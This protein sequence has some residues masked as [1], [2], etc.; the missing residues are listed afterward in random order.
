M[1]TATTR[2]AILLSGV[3][4][5]FDTPQGQYTAVAEITLEIPA[6]QF[7]AI[8][9]PSGCGKSTILGMIAGLAQPSVGAVRIGGEPLRGINHRASYM[10]Q[11]DALLPWK[12][13]LDNVAFGPELQGVP[14]RQARARAM[15][16]LERVGLHGFE[17]R[18]PH[19][20]S[21]GMRKRICL[22]Q[23]LVNDPEIMLMDE[24]F[25]GLDVQTRAMVE[26]EVLDLWAGSNKTVV[27]VTHDLE[28]AIAMSDRVVLLTAGPASHIKGDYPVTLDRPR[29]VQEV[30][31]LPAFTALYEN[32]WEGMRGEVLASYE[33][34]KTGAI[35][36]A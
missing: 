33:R 5:A 7:I 17:D 27:F 8:V 22:A 32:I 15:E 23:D 16:W 21:G 10:F 26:N 30:K 2:S 12:S 18:Y 11:Q 29:N 24:P 1:A 4:R 14:K 19:Q 9:G 36:S 35:G 20:L 28:E 6:G 3:T 31:F 13:V 25:N 34:Q